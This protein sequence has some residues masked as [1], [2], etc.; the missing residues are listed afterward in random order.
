MSVIMRKSGCRV[1]FLILT[2]VLLLS[3]SGCVTEED[4]EE[5]CTP[6]P[7]SCQETPHTE[8]TFTAHVTINAEN[9]SVTLKIY[10]GDIEDDDL[11]G[12]VTLTDEEYSTTLPLGYYSAS[13]DYKYGKYIVTA[14]DGDSISTSSTDY[15]EGPCYD[16]E[17]ADLDV[18]FDEAAFKDFLRGNSDECFIATAA[19]G[20]RYAGDVA[21][22]REFRDRV[23][24]K[25]EIGRTAVRAYYRHSPPVARIIENSAALQFFVRI[26][27]KP[28]VLVIRYPLHAVFLV[29][30]ACAGGLFWQRRS[31]NS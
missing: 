2:C 6:R 25:S 16:L 15:C 13:V 18:T 20:S 3:L 12:T 8:G 10:R 9:P 24:L 17:N 27:L 5:D 29:I 22:L 1:L 26:F 28:V 4:G 19:H 21:V 14:V 30:A 7:W 11:Y 23:L 31:R